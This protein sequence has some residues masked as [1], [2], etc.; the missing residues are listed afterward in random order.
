VSDLTYAYENSGFKPEIIPPSETIAVPAGMVAPS[1][2]QIIDFYTTWAKYIMKIVQK[3]MIAYLAERIR[4]YT[5][6]EKALRSCKVLA[7]LKN[8]ELISKIRQENLSQV[9]NSIP[10]NPNKQAR[11]VEAIQYLILSVISERMGRI[12]TDPDDPKSNSLITLD[13]DLRKNL[14]A[15]REIWTT[16]GLAHGIDYMNSILATSLKGASRRRRR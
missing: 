4:R 1:P 2:L 7:V 12:F 8:A 3:F 11:F 5:N 13:S 16:N 15:I 10:N 14:E 6:E 9:Y